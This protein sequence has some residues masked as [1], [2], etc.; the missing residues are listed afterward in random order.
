MSAQLAAVK[1][2]LSDTSWARDAAEKGVR[3]ARELGAREL[4]ARAAQRAAE[5]ARDAAEAALA[6]ALAAE[7]APP[8]GPAT[9]NADTNTTYMV[10]GLGL[11]AIG[12]QTDNWQRMRSLTATQLVTE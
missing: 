9:V 1:A 12:T 4:D 10:D 7:H 3:A 2:E 11:A 8:T 6:D 5:S